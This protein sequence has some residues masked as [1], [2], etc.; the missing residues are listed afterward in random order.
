MESAAKNDAHHRNPIF[1]PAGG[2]FKLVPPP[3]PG[4]SKFKPN[5]LTE[6]T[7][8]TPQSPGAT[9][10]GH[11]GFPPKPV[12]PPAPP[13]RPVVVATAAPSPEDDGKLIARMQ[14]LL[15]AEKRAAELEE[16]N[17][18]LLKIVN[19]LKAENAALKAK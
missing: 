4:S 3:N 14:K 7:L 12:A 9:E 18:I 1:S 15:D 10:F 5:D 13:S 8:V 6:V 17:D 11:L 16:E 19:R 2:V